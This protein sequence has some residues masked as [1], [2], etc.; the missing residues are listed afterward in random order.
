MDDMGGDLL[1]QAEQFL[2]DGNK[3]SAL[4]I[5]VEHVRK[6]PNSARGWWLLG[7]TVAERSQQ[8]ECMERVIRIDPNH[9]PAQI[10]LQ[11]LK[12]EGEPETHLTEFTP[13]FAEPEKPFHSS[14]VILDSA[15]DDASSPL[16]GK[17]KSGLA[18]PLAILSI[19]IVVGAL[20][21]VATRPGS[22]L[23]LS[24]LPISG[25][26][27]TPV[28]TVP[29][30][31]FPATWTP[32]VT[33]E[34]L[35]TNTF[36]PAAATSS[37]NLMETATIDL[38][39]FDDWLAPGVDAPDFTMHD[40]ANGQSISLS[41]YRNHPVIVFFFV[42]WCGYC[43]GQVP[44]LKRIQEDYQNEGL[45]ILGVN[46]GES[47]A[48]AKAF[49]NQYD[50]SFPV[51]NDGELEVFRLYKGSRYPTTYFIDT[52]GKVSTSMRGMM[53]YTSLTIRVSVLLNK[54]STPVP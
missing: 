12:R 52:E 35:P 21:V 53:D 54:I 29:V 20:G 47:E 38:P 1:Q 51:F 31:T 43:D 44:A 3:Q 22:F 16:T 5:L 34:P 33:S 7:F 19:C 48:K 8:I 14:P 50:L 15:K 9:V 2:K 42:T 28:N 41:D 11:T 32:T 24:L 23:Q 30:M 37:L 26:S 39:N 40:V 25:S 18:L 4:A 46:V 27:S 17:R 36:I 13:S 45:I 10:R 6:H 49:R